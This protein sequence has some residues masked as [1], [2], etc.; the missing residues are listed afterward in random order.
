[1]PAAKR[2][3]CDKA[4]EA[5]YSGVYNTVVT[6]GSYLCRRCGLALFRAH[7]QFSAGCG[8]PSFDE[9]IMGA[10]HQVMDSDGQRT[11]I[12][13]HRCE[14]HLGHVFTGEHFT[15]NNSR[16]CVNSVSVDFVADETVVDSEEAILAAGCFWGVEKNF[17]QTPGV[18]KVEVGYSGGVLEYPTYEAVCVGHSGHYEVVRVIFD[19]NKTDYL[20]ILKRFFELHDYTQS[21]GQGCDIG[22]QYQSAIFFYNQEQ[23]K[24]AEALIQSI[25]KRG[26]IVTTHLLP[27]QTFWRAEDY[28]QNY[29]GQPAKNK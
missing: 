20:M 22:H 3:I 26:D 4:T 7:S 21:N 5:P 11:E 14:A 29:Y 27:V 18:L 6:S 16:Y 2:V 1:M 13:C 28:H 17:W 10:V 8:W 24:Q 12:L 19:I 9:T 15:E 25:K 23:Q